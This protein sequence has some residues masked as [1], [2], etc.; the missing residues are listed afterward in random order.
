MHMI[1]TTLH[2][3]NTQAE[4]VAQLVQMNDALTLITALQ[5]EFK[6]GTAKQISKVSLLLQ[7]PVPDANLE[8]KRQQ[9]VAELHTQSAQIIDNLNAISA[10]M[11]STMEAVTCTLDQFIH[12]YSDVIIEILLSVTADELPKVV[13]SKSGIQKFSKPF[14]LLLARIFCKDDE[15]QLALIQELESGFVQNT[16][17]VMTGLSKR[18]KTRDTHAQ[19]KCD[20]RTL[21]RWFNGEN[22]CPNKSF[23]RLIQFLVDKNLATD[24]ELT[25]LKQLY[26]QVQVARRKVNP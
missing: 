25:T 2:P 23:Q 11:K 16:G 9:G 21:E 13:I 22:L 5:V 17:F 1:T 12:A 4:T 10:E 7:K 8:E 18:I 26:S 19:I 14:V 20:S 15:M 3:D 24:E 6:A